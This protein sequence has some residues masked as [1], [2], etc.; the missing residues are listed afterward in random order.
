MK[1]LIG[2]LFS[3]DLS[4]MVIQKRSNRPKN[5]LQVIVASEINHHKESMFFMVFN[6]SLGNEFLCAD[7]GK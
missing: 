5:C 3:R 6:L 1:V 4:W 2:I 7:E